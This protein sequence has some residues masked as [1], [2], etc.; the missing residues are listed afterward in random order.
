MK[1]NDKSYSE[2]KKELLDDFWIALD[3]VDF[4]CYRPD[5]PV[6][7]YPVTI[8]MLYMVL[9]KVDPQNDVTEEIEGAEK[10][11]DMYEE[12]KEPAYHTMAGDEVKHAK[13]LLGKMKQNHPG[14]DFSE[15]DK[16]IS[17]LQSRL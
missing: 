17:E 13:F 10:Y 7:M 8:G 12:T 3:K 15:Y 5:S 2:I 4:S 11:M 16:E 1:E 6:F 14:V 9:D